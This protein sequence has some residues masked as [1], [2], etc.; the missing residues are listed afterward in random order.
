MDSMPDST[1]ATR[2]TQ[3][4]RELASVRQGYTKLIKV[5]Q[6]SAVSD[7]SPLYGMQ[8]AV[9]VVGGNTDDDLKVLQIYS[10]REASYVYSLRFH[11]E[12]HGV[13]SSPTWFA[14][15]L[16]N[17]VETTHHS[18]TLPRSGSF[19][20]NFPSIRLAVSPSLPPRLSSS[21]P[22]LSRPLILPPTITL[23]L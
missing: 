7:R 3:P 9:A 4:L 23:P 12:V 14:V 8:P 10:L 21:V 2:Q 1:E 6:S 17:Q 15:C 13:V 19:C 16:K 5:L 20:K 18:F 22:P 11:G